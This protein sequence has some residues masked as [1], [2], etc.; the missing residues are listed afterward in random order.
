MA[1]PSS[2]DNLKDD[3][4]GSDQSD[5]VDHAGMH[6]EERVAINAIQAELGVSPSGAAATVADLLRSL[7]AGLP[8]LQF[9]VVGLAAGEEPTVAQ[10]TVGGV[11]TVTIG[12]PDGATGAAAAE[13]NF[14]FDTVP[15]AP[16]GTPTVDV[17]G[18]YPDLTITLGVPTGA[19]GATGAT[20]TA[21]QWNTAQTINAQTDSY[22]LVAGDAGKLVTV[23]RGTAV[24]VTVDTSTA[25]SA[26][27]RIDLAQL[28]AGQVT[29]VAS[30]VTVSATPSLKLRAQYSAASLVCISSGVYLLLGD[31]DA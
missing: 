11:T 8:G 12:I 16:G 28:G 27:Q 14:T 7:E 15:V 10:E 18:T 17:T 20:G 3:F 22:T 25:L 4:D 31:L 2:L 13:P 6:N 24:N 1:Y 23:N 26:G 19:T 9:E 30:G 29:V 5:V 21:G